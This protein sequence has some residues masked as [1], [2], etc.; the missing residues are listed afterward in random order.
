M[1][2][3]R[4][5]VKYVGTLGDIR[6][7]KIKGLSG[8]YAGL[9]GGP[10]AEQIKTDPAFKRTRE[11]MNEFGGCGLVGKA[12]R[13]A[14][15]SLVKNMADPRFTG[16]LTA[17]LKKINLEDGSEARGRRAILISQVPRHLVGLDFNKNISL[18]GIFQAPHT[19]TPT[20]TRESTTLDVPAFNPL[21]FI[22]APA[23]ATHFRLIN[24]VV[25]ISDFQFNADDKTYERKE[26][27]LSELVDIQYSDYTALDVT[28]APISLTATLP[29]SPTLT[30]DVS[31][32]ACMGIE[33]YQQVGSEY[34][35]FNSGNALKIKDVLVG[36]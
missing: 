10:T 11:N 29:G 23:G 16:R 14:M 34:Y 12:I 27:A 2:K 5:V 6:H 3:Q 30:N 18:D 31:V 1:A 15:S 7:F 4:G 9:V 17:I 36:A 32:L 19:L 33:F 13:T 20:A 8:Y 25:S 35:L 24:S 28:T 22:N 21:S 26:A